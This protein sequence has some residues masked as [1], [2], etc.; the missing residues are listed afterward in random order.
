MNVQK[1]IGALSLPK[2]RRLT[3]AVPI[4]NTPASQYAQVLAPRNQESP[5]T[6]KITMVG[7]MVNLGAI[8]ECSVGDQHRVYG[9][10]GWDIEW[11]GRQ[12]ALLLVM[13]VEMPLSFVFDTLTLPWTIAHGVSSRPSLPPPD[14]DP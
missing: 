12:P 2:A 3:S 8:G 4:A 7:T 9:G 13:L 10:V 5:L 6:P 11:T 14:Q 1:L